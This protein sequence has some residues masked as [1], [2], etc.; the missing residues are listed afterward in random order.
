MPQARLSVANGK[1][2][3]YRRCRLNVDAKVLGSIGQGCL[4]EDRF[5]HLILLTHI[6]IQI[7]NTPN[8]RNEQ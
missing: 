4:S 3:I 2:S 1:V 8:E 6:P 7:E 5:H